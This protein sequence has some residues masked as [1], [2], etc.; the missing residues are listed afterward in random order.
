MKSERIEPITELK[1]VAAYVTRRETVV[2]NNMPVVEKLW[3]SH[4]WDG[5]PNRWLRTRSW[6][7]S[8]RW[9]ACLALSMKCL[10]RF[11]CRLLQ[12]TE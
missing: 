2:I 9:S 7:T 5:S 8:A 1:P 6:A 12:I 10:Q 11:G 4:A 3:L